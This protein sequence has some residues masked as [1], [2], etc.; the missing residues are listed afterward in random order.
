MQIAEHFLELAIMTNINF[1]YDKTKSV[2]KD[3]KLATKLLEK[4]ADPTICNFKKELCRFF[5]LL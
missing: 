1:V 2:L 4:G 5:R 3:D